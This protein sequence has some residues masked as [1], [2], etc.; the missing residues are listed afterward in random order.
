MPDRGLLCSRSKV[1]LPQ[2]A[3]DRRTTRGVGYEHTVADHLRDEL[4][5]RRLRAARARTRE[6][7]QRLI[8]LTSLHRRILCLRLVGNVA[9][10]PIEYDLLIEHIVDRLHDKRIGRAGSGA[11]AASHTIKR[12]QG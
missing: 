2:G 1:N 5:I 3:P 11:N 10:A 9:H 4:G 12:R 8:E 6:L 7:E